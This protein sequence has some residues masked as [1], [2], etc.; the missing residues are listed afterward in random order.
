MPNGLK[1]RVSINSSQL[2]PLTR[3]TTSPATTTTPV[4]CVLGPAGPPPLPAAV[5]GATQIVGG[6][7]PRGG[8]L[9]C[10]GGARPW[11][12]GTVTATDP[13]GAVVAT[14][15]VAA[16]QTFAFDLSPGTYE[17][18]TGV[19]G[20]RTASDPDGEIPLTATFQVVP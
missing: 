18:A 1:I 6:I 11:T 3:A 14:Q 9:E 20:G 8:P 7:F 4:P 16:G 12:S 15:T 10:A 17:L 5:S 19:G 2:I 13:S